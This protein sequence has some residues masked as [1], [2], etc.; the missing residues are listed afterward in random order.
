M[1]LVRAQG[2]PSREKLAVP[3]LQERAF[4]MSVIRIQEGKDETKTMSGTCARDAAFYA[5]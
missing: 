4:R 1:D 5:R 3:G 2:M